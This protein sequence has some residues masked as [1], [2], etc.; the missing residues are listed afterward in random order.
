MN[1]DI[2]PSTKT[3]SRSRVVVLPRSVTK[4]TSVSRPVVHAP[5]D[6]LSSA[7]RIVDIAPTSAVSAL[8]KPEA[9][10][11][12]H[13]ALP[14]SVVHTQMEH[15]EKK[16]VI[17][18]ALRGYHRK[19]RAKRMRELF[20]SKQ[21]GFIGLAIMVFTVTGYIAFDT[22]VTNAHVKEQLS[23]KTIGD[24]TSTAVDTTTQHT[25]EG[26]DKMPVTPADIGK[27]AVAP[28]L[29]R[30]IYIGKIGVAAR[31]LP[32]SVNTDGSVQAPKNIF[33]AGWYS[34]SVKPGEIGAMFIDGHSSGSTHEGL[35]GNLS[36]L[37]EGDTLQIEKGDGTRLTYQVTHTEVVK[38]ADVDMKKMLL[39]YGNALRA[40]NI[41]T[42]TGQWTNEGGTETLNQRVL[43]YTEQIS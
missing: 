23:G 28:D 20:L 38:L 33:D 30:A 43:I 21:A 8:H 39:P 10:S 17:S 5:R 3:R 13:S 32:M 27:Y 12:I 9:L 35:F 6:S 16:A 18:R 7:R 19:N 34:G 4:T 11:K 1:N 25:V 15:A 41:M 29:P 31:T 14:H 40:L 24:D 42:C 22:I 2:L 36:K 37:V 26:S